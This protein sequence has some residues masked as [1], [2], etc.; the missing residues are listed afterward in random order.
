MFYEMRSEKVAPHSSKCSD[1]EGSLFTIRVFGVMIITQACSGR[2]PTP[3]YARITA[4]ESGSRTRSIC[5]KSDDLMYDKIGVF[6]RPDLERTLSQERN[7]L[8]NRSGRATL[9]KLNSKS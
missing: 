2:V 5:S 1:T 8:S 4:L 3:I 7:Y 9:V 6:V